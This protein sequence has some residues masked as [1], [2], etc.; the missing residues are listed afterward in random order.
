MVLIEKYFKNL[1]SLQKQ[2]FEALGELYTEWNGKI[3]VISRK[4]VQYLYLHHILHSLSLAKYI[5]FKPG[6]RILDIGTGGGFPGIPLAIMFPESFF[7]LVDSVAKKIKVVDSIAVSLE[8]KNCK[9]KQIRAEEAEGKFDFVVCRAVAPL[10]TI[11]PWVRKSI[12]KQS[13]YKQE[14]GLICLKGG[15]LTEE[16]NISDRVKI[17]EISDYFDEPFFISKK[18]VH[19]FIP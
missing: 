11:L 7:V 4:D 15:D 9:A 18:I 3:N 2:Q 10:T 8:L 6:T 13:V 17:T 19:V 1:T 5:Q 14:K 16:L 12:L